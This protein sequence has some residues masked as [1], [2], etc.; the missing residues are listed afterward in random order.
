LNSD[1][2]SSGDRIIGTSGHLKPVRVVV[3]L[4]SNLGDRRG[5]LDW[6]VD[7][8]RD[9]LADLRVSPTSKPSL[10]ACRT[11]SRRI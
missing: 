7:R 1:I 9:L 6:A 10:S 4:G 8:L 2:G 3:A 5:H 11:N